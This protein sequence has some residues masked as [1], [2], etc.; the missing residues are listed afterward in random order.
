MRGLLYNLAAHAS[1]MLVLRDC[2]L[3][4]HLGQ[5]RAWQAPELKDYTEY[6]RAH[7]AEVLNNLSTHPDKERRLRLFLTGGR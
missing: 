5:D 4:F 1:N 6:N 2:H 7:A 3:T